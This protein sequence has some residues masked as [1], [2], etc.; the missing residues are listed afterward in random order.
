M[1]A[2]LLADLGRGE[3]VPT[4]ARRFHAAL[5]GLAAA[6]AEDAGRELVVLT[7]GC[8][9]N[10]LLGELCERRLAA[11]GFRVVRPARYPANDGGISLGQAW[12]ASRPQWGDHLG[13]REH[14]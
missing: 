14:P 10:R 3:P 12:V 9:Q 11:R 6:F 13:N 5:A 7:G 2:A 1:V 4:V 8:F